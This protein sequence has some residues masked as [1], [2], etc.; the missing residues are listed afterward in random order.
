MLVK[1][2][3]GIRFHIKN[4]HER[5]HQIYICDKC[6]YTIKKPK[7]F[8]TQ[9]LLNMKVSYFLK[10]VTEQLVKNHVKRVHLLTTESE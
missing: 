5:F 3:Q 7:T 8:K 6:E 9:V 1:T 4:I 2:D 10:S